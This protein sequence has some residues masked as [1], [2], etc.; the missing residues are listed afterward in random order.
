M[1][2][3][4]RLRRVTS[5][6]ARQ[7]SFGQGQHS[8]CHHPMKCKNQ[9]FRTKTRPLITLGF[10]GAEFRCRITPTKYGYAR[11]STDGQ[12]I[13]AQVRQLRAAGAPGVPRDGK[14]HEDRSR[15]APPRA[16]P[17]RRRRRAHGHAPRSLGAIDAR[18][19]EHPRGDRR[20]GGRIP[21][22]WRRVGRHHHSARPLDAHRARGAGRV[23]ARVDPRVPAKAARAP[24][25]TAPSSA[26]SPSSRPT[27]SAR[28]SSAAMPAKPR[29][30]G[31]SYNVS[32]SPIS[33]LSA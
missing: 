28:R 3:Q 10:S 2:G 17:V 18:P 6:R 19:L 9:D 30:I 14:R 24:W 32:H 26:S 1:M 20:P 23:R 11:V 5:H 21:I 33:R 29:D 27:R 4:A 15:P 13:D 31:R 16:R 22:A 8:A 7:R 12:S 25:R